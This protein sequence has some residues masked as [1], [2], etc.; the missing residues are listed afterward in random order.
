MKGI[1]V[2]L[3]T[4]VPL[5]LTSGNPSDFSIMHPLGYVHTVPDRILLLFKNCSGTM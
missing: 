5:A 2:L 3:R 4:T 1:G